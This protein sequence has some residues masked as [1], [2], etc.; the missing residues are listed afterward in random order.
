M[1]DAGV[2]I[3]PRALLVI[4]CVFWTLGTNIGWLVYCW[5]ILFNYYSTLAVVGLNAFMIA[6]TASAQGI[7]AFYYLKKYLMVGVV[8][9]WG[10]LVRVKQLSK[11]PRKSLIVWIA[12]SA[13]LVVTLLFQFVCLSKAASPSTTPVILGYVL[14]GFNSITLVGILIGMVISG[15]FKAEQVIPEEQDVTHESNE[16]RDQERRITDSSTSPRRRTNA[17]GS[18]AQ[19]LGAQ[20]P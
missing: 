9:G 2:G 8:S 5:Y 18:T 4:Y 1:D 19:V 11:A 6:V 7:S 13:G 3:P 17:R 20:Q 10:Q 16:G 15:M 12:S 14:A